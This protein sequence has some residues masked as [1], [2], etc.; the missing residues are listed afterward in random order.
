MI[1]II[2]LAFVSIIPLLV[3]ALGGL[4]S[5]KSGVT[6]IAL[7]GLM[8]LGAF[9][10]T[11]TIR[12]LQLG[13]NPPPQQIIFF[14]GILVGGIT[15][16]LFSLAHAFASI[17]LNADQTISATAINLFAPAFAIFTAR[18]VLGGQQVKFNSV[19]RIDKVPFLG[20]IPLLG[21]IFFQ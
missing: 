19:F 3:V 12:I 21:E 15:G 14:I 16:G 9:F 10:G 8:L 13:S 7:E 2:Q 6:N 17:K 4:M 5:E 18:S 1:E 11:W 20:D